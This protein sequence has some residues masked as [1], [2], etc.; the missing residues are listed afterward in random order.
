[1]RGEGGWRP[2]GDSN[3]APDGEQPSEETARS[4]EK[5][6]ADAIDDC[7][8]H[9]TISDRNRHAQPEPIEPPADPDE[10]LRGAIVAAVRAGLWGRARALIDVAEQAAE[11]KPTRIV[12]LEERRRR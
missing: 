4:I 5:T 8:V 12:R 2:Q 11:P 3:R 10:A 6:G 9:A 7:K 1:M